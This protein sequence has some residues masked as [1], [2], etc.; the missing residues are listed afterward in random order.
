[1]RLDPGFAPQRRR[2]WAGPACFPGLSRFWP[3]NFEAATRDRAPSG[4]MLLALRKAL[5][6]WMDCFSPGWFSRRLSG[7]CC[8]LSAICFSAEPRSLFWLSSVATVS[9]DRAGRG[10]RAGLEEGDCFQH[11]FARPGC[12]G[13]LG[14][15]GRSRLSNA[16]TTEAVLGR[17]AWQGLAAEGILD[18]S[19]GFQDLTAFGSGST[20]GMA[21]GVAGGGTWLL[22]D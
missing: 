9:T 3:Q 20:A 19:Q 13:P 1:M 15:A 11:G 5:R 16:W 4:K 22:A 17:A 12:S 14:V 2:R 8:W 7:S 6:S 10:K 21:A 18:L